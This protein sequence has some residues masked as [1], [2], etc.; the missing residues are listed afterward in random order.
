MQQIKHCEIK[1]LSNINNSSGIR[2]II[3]YTIYYLS[4]ITIILFLTNN[5]SY[6]QN[7]SII[8]VQQP[9]FVPLP[10]QNIFKDNH[11][12][13]K[14]KIETDTIFSEKE[15]SLTNPIYPISIHSKQSLSEDSLLI[16]SEQECKYCKVDRLDSLL[17][18]WFYYTGRDT[19][20]FLTAN[21]RN[22]FINDIPDSVFEDRL[23]KII[24]PIEMSYNKV[25]Q[26][27][28]DQ[29]IKNGKWTA[30]KLLGLS[31]QFFPLFETFLDSYN[32]P[33]EL[34]YLAVI[35]S[36]LNPIA[37][38][39]SG[40]AG[41]WQFMFQTGKGYG[42][43]INSYIDERMDIVKSTEAACKYLK[44]LYETYNDWILA[45]ASYNCGPGTVNNAI[46]RA[47][48]K[49]NYWDIYPYLPNQTRNYVPRFIAVTYMF[50]YANEHNFKPEA[51]PFYTDIDTVMIKKE[52]HFAQ[53][54]SVLGISV[55]QSRELNPQ[56]RYDIIPAK[57][58]QYPLRIRHQYVGKFI[59]L[60]DS[61]YKFKDSIFFNPQKYRYKP[62]EQYDDYAPLATQPEGTVELNYTV[63]SGD[64]IGLISEWYGV[65][66]SEIKAWNGIGNNI[67]VGQV[68]KIYVKKELVEKYRNVNN[69]SFGDK[70]KMVGIDPT[71]NT[72][73]EEPLDPNY[74]YYTVKQGDSPYKIAN[75]Y[76]D[77]SVEDILK[78]NDN[79]DPSSLRIGQKLKI[80]KKQ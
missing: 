10:F 59:E 33:I 35:E 2:K 60:E 8:K 32:M 37:K 43:E 39:G 22:N 58:K 27:Y 80:R 28:L 74:E 20:K 55:E 67:K 52:L 9:I 25:V 66:N 70:Q 41:L 14:N 7:D 45:I 6:S 65:K 69:M 63:K 54:D 71:T 1:L 30:P 16:L 73:K 24:S 53:L 56:Y 50:E 38:S 4:F 26:K 64:V 62:N 3:K 78:L 49:T 23:R 47:G 17:Q 12:Y 34:K 36:G 48:G 72:P 31:Y 15:D 40:A 21:N 5:F 18:T 68:L 29:Y 61:I 11:N 13:N 51:Y 57:A 76:D 77:V 75:L 79:I 44:K 42:L 46:R 19:I